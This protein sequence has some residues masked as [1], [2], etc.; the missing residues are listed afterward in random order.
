MRAGVLAMIAA[1]CAGSAQ[2]QQA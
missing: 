2:A 1:A